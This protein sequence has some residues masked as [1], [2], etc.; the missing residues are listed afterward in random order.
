MS[1]RVSPAVIGAFVVASFAILVAA[2]IVVGSGRMFARPIRY[3]CMFQGNLNGLKVGAPVKVRGVQIGTV[4]E[5]EL[6][7]S[8]SEGRL[9]P[10]IKELRLPV[11]VDLDRSQLLARGGTGAALEK[12]NFKELLKQG[13]RAQLNTES[14]LTGLLYIDLDLHP[15]APMNLA[16]EPGGAYPEIPTVQTNLEQLQERLLKTLDKFEKIDFQALVVSITDAANSIKTLTGSPELK[17]TLESLKETVANLNRAITST[18]GLL[19]N[20]NSKIGP[21]VAA[22]QKN[23]DEANKTMK[24]TRAALVRLQQTLDPDSPLA[25]HL[26]QTLDQLSETGRSL[27]DLTDYLQRNPGA[28]IRGR[29]VPDKEK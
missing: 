28:L 16:L 10:G 17:A 24:D 19:N 14:L 12:S 11:I 3:I 18:R 26:N 9:R 4:A 8:P 29:Y 25:V 22:L 15:G 6:R 5:I 21:L 23:S 7:L 20:A 1:K 13:L 27:Q 2:L